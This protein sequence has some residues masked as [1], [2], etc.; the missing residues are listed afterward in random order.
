[1]AILHTY[2]RPA[3]LDEALAL[4]GSRTERLAPLAGGTWLVGQL[5]LR[6]ITDLNG[7]VDLRDAGLDAIQE[8]DGVLH[9]GAM[10]TMTDNA[11]HPALRELANGL[12]PR[13]ARGEGPQN[14]RNAATIGG[15]IAR[16]EPD[17][18][19]Y[20]ALLAL[21]ASVTLHRPD[22]ST[23]TVPLA[24]L[25]AGV[26]GTGDLITEVQ[27]ANRPLKGGTARIARTPSDRPIVAAIA[28]QDATGP[29][30][31]EVR[32]ALCGLAPRPILAGS[33]LDPPDDFKASAAYRL[34][35]ADIVQERA[36][37]EIAG[38]PPAGAE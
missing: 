25:E 11:Q 19:F 21:D 16:A 38:A 35:M 2:Y 6:T 4:L 1:M 26:G 28:V 10:A 32:V 9:V 33:P 5:E 12:L 7:V 14:L 15:T 30:T 13:A 20:A 34:A 17:S 18:E 23:R 8:H 27:I 31:S 3:S 24:E 37:A 36:I 29:D 22:G